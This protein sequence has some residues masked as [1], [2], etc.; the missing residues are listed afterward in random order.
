MAPTATSDAAW[1]AVAQNLRRVVRVESWMIVSVDL[2]TSELLK[3]AL[4]SSQQESGH[5]KQRIGWRFS[6][7]SHRWH[8]Q[9]PEAFT[10]LVY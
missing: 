1:H 7:G 8:G 4:R 3:Q 6:G 10:A 2:V 5:P 9:D